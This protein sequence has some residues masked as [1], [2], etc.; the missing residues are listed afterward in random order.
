MAGSF[1]TSKM[2]REYQAKF[3]FDKYVECSCIDNVDVEEPYIEAVKSIVS[4]TSSR[5]SL[6]TAPEIL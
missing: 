5:K 3:G 2:A 4:L 1:V 6:L